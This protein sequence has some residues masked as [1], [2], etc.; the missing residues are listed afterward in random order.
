MIFYD[1]KDINFKIFLFINQ[2]FHNF[3]ILDLSKIE[4]LITYISQI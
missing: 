2:I 1:L 3:F 4:I